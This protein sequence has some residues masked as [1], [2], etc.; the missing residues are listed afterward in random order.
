[1][2][3]CKKA[4]ITS[5]KDFSPAYFWGINDRMELCTLKKQLREMK[6]AG[7]DSVCLHPFPP[8]WRKKMRPSRMS[9]EYLSEDY[10]KIIKELVKECRRLGMHYYLYDEGGFPSGGA[11]G[12]V[13]ASDPDRFTAYQTEKSDGKFG[14]EKVQYPEGIANYPDILADGCVDRFIELTHEAHRKYVGKFFGDTIKYVF[15]DE[16]MAFKWTHDLPQE[17]KKRK[18]YDIMPFAAEILTGK[19]HYGA[20]EISRARI[21]YHE[22]MSDLF[23]ERF[24]LP[25]RKW[26]RRNG[27]ISGGHLNIDHEM[28]GNVKGRHGNTLRSLREMDLPGID[29][30]WRQVYKEKNNYPFAKVASSAANQ[31]GRGQALAEVF[32]V[33]GNGL[34]PFM[35]KY[36]TDYLLAQG[37][38]LFVLSLYMQSYY[39]HWMS[40]CRPHSGPDDPLWQYLDIFHKYIGRASYIMSLGKAFAPTVVYYDARSIWAGAEYAVQAQEE[41]E[42]ICSKLAEKHCCFDFADEYS[43][44][45]AVVKNGKIRIGKAEYSNIV[46]PESQWFTDA[47]K[48]KLAEFKAHGGRIYSIAELDNIPSDLQITG[49]GKDLRIYRRKYGRKDIFF[50]HNES[51]EERRVSIDFGV[52][53]NI[54]VCD[55]MS[56]RFLGCD[57]R[58]FERNFAPGEGMIFMS[59]VAP[60]GKYEDCENL[61]ELAEIS[62]NWQLRPLKSYLVGD[63]F[64]KQNDLKKSYVNCKLG[65]WR[66]YVGEDFSGNVEYSTVF[67][68]NGTEED[69]F[70]DLGEVCYCCTVELNGH[71]ERFFNAPYRMKCRLKKGRN[72]LKVTVVNTF[73]NALGS[74]ETQKK[75]QQWPRSPYE[76]KQLLFEKDSLKSGLIGPV[77]IFEKKD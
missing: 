20:L 74:E 48:E 5:P 30:I 61:H 8:E 22:V 63:T 36:L 71:K 43:L 15:T 34:T 42:K 3:F 66:K 70:L 19:Q 58:C 62:E 73:S 53:D 6:K 65:D 75:F 51:F 44:A 13:Y 9:P 27:L 10:F 21:D 72:V 33:Y 31:N 50:V 69:V 23:R 41:C 18:G 28:A 38:N 35:A 40:G 14:I 26:C 68:W 45:E 29:V 67:D 46:M 32:A 77:K 55:A 57:C 24:L 17:F 76:D 39:E 59:N 12:K 54:V 37:I 25:I 7:L 2:R 64:Y 11:C 4:F 1:M 52:A 56:G 16:P 49:N 60:D 47:V